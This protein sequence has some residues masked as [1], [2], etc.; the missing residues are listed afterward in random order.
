MRGA[1]A[2]AAARPGSFESKSRSG[3]SSSCAGRPLRASA[4]CGRD[5][6]VRALARRRARV[7]PVPDAVDGDREP[8]EAERAAGSA[9][10][11]VSTSASAAGPSHAE[12]LDADLAELAVPARLRPLE[13]ELRAPYQ[14][15]SGSGS[16]RAALDSMTAR[17]TPA[18][19][20]GRSVRDRPLRSGERVHLLVDDVGR[21]ARRSGRRAPSTRRP[22]C[23]PRRSRSGP[24]TRRHVLRPRRSARSSGG[25]RSRVPLTAA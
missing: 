9:K 7:A 6:L 22:A 21:L 20:S 11:I 10:S 15:R 14:R 17:T 1:P 3:F 19:F 23:G 24:K 18:V 8:G 5:V 13:A 4:A 2:R 25:N 16:P 12:E